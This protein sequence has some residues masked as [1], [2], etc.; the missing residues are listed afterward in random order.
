MYSNLADHPV[1][2]I[3]RAVKMGN[4]LSK[5]VSAKSI[6]F[7]SS[8]S[9]R[10]LLSTLENA[11]EI[12]E[13][14]PEL[15]TSTITTLKG[16]SF[17]LI[18]LIARSGSPEVMK[19]L[20]EKGSSLKDLEGGWSLMD[21][22]CVSENLPMIDY[23]IEEGL[24]LT[25]FEVGISPIENAIYDNCLQTLK[26]TIEKHEYSCDALLSGKWTPLGRCCFFNHFLMARYLLENGADV[27]LV[28]TKNVSAPIQIAAANQ[29]T[30]IVNLLIELGADVNKADANGIDALMSASRGGYRS[31]V[32]MLL[33]GGAS[34]K[35]ANLKGKTALYIASGKGHTG[36]ALDL[37]QAGADV[38]ANGGGAG[39]TPLGR[40]VIKNK[41]KMVQFLLTQGAEIKVCKPRGAPILHI[42]VIKSS[43]LVSLLLEKTA[44]PKHLTALTRTAIHPFILQ[45]ME[46]WCNQ[47]RCSLMLGRT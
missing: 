24:S 12:L 11:T 5:R 46:I 14:E 8:P 40:A 16:N 28:S 39:S 17:P 23:L 26:H 13:L 42:A 10:K 18:F 37:I 47:L 30:E 44:A 9:Q 22:A 32:Q 15:A 20:K 2:D 7:T 29:H 36:I 31:V 38:N 3:F 4:Q 41:P 6:E 45:L 27:N 19:L 43:E 34:P 35:V 21:F 33:K 25:V 1:F